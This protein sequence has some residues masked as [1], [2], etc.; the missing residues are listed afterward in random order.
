MESK[1]RKGDSEDTACKK[2]RKLCGNEDCQ[3]CFARCLASS[4]HVEE[5]KAANPSLN[6]LQI[7][8]FTD[9]HYD[10][11]CVCGHTFNAT[12]ITV[13]RGHWCHYCSG[14]KLCGST[15]CLP[16]FNRSLASS[17]RMAEFLDANPD[18]NP[19]MIPISSNLKYDWLCECGHK[20]KMSCENVERGA[21]C[22]YCGKRKL[23]GDPNCLQCFDSSIA[24]SPRA[25]E[26]IAANPDLDPLVIAIS[27]H[28]M[29]DWQCGNCGHTF[30]M[31]CGH[32]TA[33]QWCPF[34]GKKKLC[35]DAHCLRCFDGSM[36]SSPHAEEFIAANPGLDLLTLFISSAKK[37]DWLC[38]RCG[39][40]FNTKCNSVHNKQWCPQCAGKI[41]GKKECLTC[42]P[43]CATCSK[44][45]YFTL[46]NGTRACH[47]CFAASGESRI[48]VRLEL[49]FLAELQRLASHEFLEPTSWD[50][51]V[52]PGL[53]YRPDMLWAYDENGN[54]FNTTGAC[55]LALG[56]IKHMVILEVLEIGI[57]QHSKARHVSDSQR[58]SEIRASLTGITVDFVYVVVA[59]YNHPTAD[60][61][62]KFFSVNKL[63]NTYFVGR[64]RKK[65]W[66]ERVKATLRSLTDA[67]KQ[68][69]GRTVFIGS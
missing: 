46:K 55:K 54:L 22:P 60:P 20:F 51:A 27:S 28:T 9:V 58:E 40:I 30:K 45:S 65:A 2:R 43:P 34:C 49:F 44:K 63:K 18:L 21:W 4:P 12:C 7:T 19:F 39:H 5:F 31:A 29:F 52:L 17:S 62:D 38:S 56:E 69:L 67:R 24:S 6:P 1:K 41:C 11:K 50:C 53:S 68:R 64:S 35:G 37:F 15:T 16:C 32:V 57:E 13:H 14:K 42:A 25:E 10:W 59:A 3:T 23:C 66:E 61:A 47:G 33:G 8:L 26:F 48:K 36:A